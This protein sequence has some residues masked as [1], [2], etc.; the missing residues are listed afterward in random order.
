MATGETGV[1]SIQDLDTIVDADAHVEETLDEVMAHMDDKYEG[2]KK[3]ISSTNHPKSE[4]FTDVKPLPSTT[5]DE[6][7]V[8]RDRLGEQKY[9]PEDKLQEM[10]KYNIDYALLSPGPT[11]AV[12]TVNNSRCAVALANG[13][14]SWVVDTFLDK[15]DRF[16]GG[17]VVPPQKPDRGAEEIDRWA[18]EDGIVG[19]HLIASGLVPPPGHQWY[20]PIYEAAEDNDLTIMMHSAG[21]KN[22]K[23]FPVQYWWN[24]T[25]AEDHAITHPFSHMWNLTTM[26]MQGVPERFP[27]LEFLIQEAGL[28]WIPYLAYRLDEHSMMYPDQVPILERLPSEYIKDQFDFVTQPINQPHD[29]PEYLATMVNM[30]GP[31][32]IMYSGDFPHPDFDPPEQ[33][34][35]YLQPYLDEDNI[36]GV[37]G[38]TA[39]D[40]LF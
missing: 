18:D 24:E 9:T 2:A 38:E 23:T 22:A 4:V 13:Y 25:Y 40:A 28:G 39:K 35:N 14:N 10:E 21:A 37:M 16:R 31:E 30:I 26:I 20:D 19:V 3:L 32:N 15:S 34:F 27:D 36:R 33:L 17:V 12:N 8:T 7:Q 29:N 6:M 5:S 11:S 1:S